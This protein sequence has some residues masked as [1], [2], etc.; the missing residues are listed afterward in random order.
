MTQGGLRIEDKQ[1]IEL[2][3]KLIDCQKQESNSLLKKL[4]N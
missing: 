2:N 3:L 4:M 1:K